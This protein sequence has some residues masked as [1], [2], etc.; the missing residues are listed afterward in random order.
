MVDALLAVHPNARPAARVTAPDPDTVGAIYLESGGPVTPGDDTRAVGTPVVVTD[1]SRGWDVG[2]AWGLEGLAR[3]FGGETVRC[4]DRAPARHADELGPA[5]AQRSCAVPLGEFVEYAA[6]RPRCDDPAGLAAADAPFYCNG[7][8]AFSDLSG[9]GSGEVAAAFPPP[10]FAQAVDHSLDI[11]R[12]THRALLPD[13]PPAAA[14]AIAASVDASLSKVFAGPAG[15]VTRL[16]QDAG[17]AHAWLGQ[18]AG[19]KLFVCYPPDDS[20]H[21]YPIPGETETVQ[22][23]VD[24]LSPRSDTAPPA[25]DPTSEQRPLYWARARP[26]VFVLEAGEVVLVPRGWW[27]YAAVGLG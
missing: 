17:D 9:G 4:N 2:M 11:V 12:Q 7:W 22:S 13:Q 3:R 19:R 24:P 14:D 25:W 27:H 15:T 23:A 21:L 5:G 16:H 10:H 18:A 20:P 26:V 1:G 6:S 8:R